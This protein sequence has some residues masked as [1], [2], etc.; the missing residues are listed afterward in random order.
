MTKQWRSGTVAAI[1]AAATMATATSGEAASP[2]F[3]GKRVT[4]TISNSAGGGMDTSARHVAK[5]LGKHIPGNPTVVVKNRPG[6]GH[7]I[8][9]NWFQE[10][11]K[12]DGTDL[13]YTAS[14][15]IDQFNR[16]GKRIKFNP[17]KYDYVGSIK[18][19]SSV[20]L[21]RHEA[22]K[23]LRNPSAKPVV[24]GDTDGVRTHTAITVMAKRYLGDNFRWIV[25]YKGGKELRL[26]IQQGE[27]DV[28]G[29][30]NQRQLNNLIKKRK[31]VQ[32]LYQSG[33][34]RRPDFAKIPTI[35]ELIAKKNVPS[36]E[37][38][39]FKFWMAGEPIDHI[40]A[41]PPGGNS[42]AVGIMREAYKKVAKD[43]EFLRLVGSVMGKNINPITGPETG[44]LILIATT[45]SKKARATL[46]K[47]RV[48]HGLPIGKAKKR[49]KKK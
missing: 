15:V 43:P 1:V 12:R 18:F 3:E 16:G 40:L 37:M 26:A 20:V 23:R 14:S 19:A 42:K 44:R 29:T 28:W 17:Q 10:K 24:V 32:V 33:Q 31:I 25:G 45:V 30:K 11:A 35:W 6:G 36:K 22:V 41:L 13:L 4:L 38:D 8:G 27:I 47:I 48:E 7:T 5:I 34:V 9:N 21:I 46:N 39:A 49:K 2:Y